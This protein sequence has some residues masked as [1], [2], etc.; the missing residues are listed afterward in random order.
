MDDPLLDDAR[1][2]VT[3]H[4]ASA[5]AALRAAV[6][7]AKAGDPLAPVT[8]T[9]P[10]SVAGLAL[11][12]AL[13]RHGAV[14]TRFLPFARLAE[15]LGAP[16]LAASGLRPLVT[17]VRRA[18]VRR[19][20]REHDGPLA[21]VAG[22]PGT[23]RS[24]AATFRD[25]DAAPP[26]ALAALASRGPRAEAVA[27]LYRR[28]R[29]LTAGFY[30]ERDLA[31]AAAAAVRD[32]D[33]VLDDVGQVVV[34]LPGRPGAGHDDLIAA[35]AEASLLRVVVGLTGDAAADTAAAE[36]VARLEPLLGTPDRN[37]PGAPPTAQRCV[38]VPDAAE[39]ARFAAREVAAHLDAGVPLHRL[40]V[41]TPRP[42][43]ALHRLHDVFT[44]AGIPHHLRS[45][46]RLG[47]SAA[48]RGLR[49]LLALAEG[50]LARQDLVA[51]IDAAPVLEHPAGHPAPVSDW[52]RLS[53]E[54][55]VVRGARQW[56]AR[57]NAHERRLAA[58]GDEGVERRGGSDSVGTDVEIASRARRFAGELHALLH[59]APAG[60]WRSLAQWATDLLVR[61]LGT[62]AQRDE[63][64]EA[65]RDAFTRV[66]E[67]LHGLA[68]LD[69]VD[70]EPS[71]AVFRQAV[72]DV[73]DAPAGRVG[74]FGHGVFLGTL[75][76]LAGTDF[77]H[78]HVVGMA[79][80]EVPA[81]RAEDALLSD[82][83]RRHAGVAPRAADRRDE[84][85]RFLAALASAPERVLV[86]ARADVR[87]QQA[88]LP[89]RWFLET[90]E[91]LLGEPVTTAALDARWEA[92]GPVTRLPS[93]QA[94]LE[95]APSP[96][97]ESERDVREMLAARRAGAPVDTTA[98]V[99]A[100]PH[101]AA[102]LAADAARH[103]GVPSPWNGFVGPGGAMVAD[104]AEPLSPTALET[105]ATCPARFFLGRVL[106]LGERD[107]P[108][109]VEQLGSADRGSLVHEI[110]ET[111]VVE[112]GS[113]VEPGAPWPPEA[114]ARA[115]AIADEVCAGYE[116]RGRTGHPLLWEYERRRILDQLERA[117][118]IDDVLRAEERSRPLA[119][120]MTFGIGEAAPVEV[121]L[122]D[123]R[124][125]RL[126]GRADRVDEAGARLVV[127]DYKTGSPSPYAALADD[128]VDAG[129]RLQLPVYALAARD[130]FGDRPVDAHYWFVSDRG[131][132][133]RVP[134]DGSLTPE[135]LDRFHAVLAT[136]VDGI[137]RGHFPA[138]PGADS[139]DYVRRRDSFEH[140]R[141]CA[142]DRLCTASRGDTWEALAD[143]PEM[144][145]FVALA[146]GGD[147]AG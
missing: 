110:L 13:A 51:W 61:Y 11:R 5:F 93:V 115:R 14:N 137:E 88:R 34:H 52:D 105:W 143:R 45:A 72:A 62:E 108:E 123:G 41:V 59:R 46:G 78:V 29:E 107:E 36:L 96:A 124:A 67:G 126:R 58:L 40:A 64:P 125:V 136:I 3:P 69:D 141:W 98:A 103:S 79:E 76:D 48:G 15:L 111:L 66:T 74:R 18:A 12:R 146:P 54:A 77:A 99:V 32:G 120:E 122:P 35:L 57:L 70:P 85:H 102:G 49:G 101:L 33:R 147:G 60:S 38:V 30:D 31:G 71:V 127:L 19:A 83:E 28:G 104:T 75:D 80:G 144:A 131:R 43:P 44:T 100:R 145:P 9:P 21:G 65:E 121:P 23:E 109:E 26:E 16:R 130:R 20:L 113:S 6:D 140:C 56:E 119:A 129:R 92:S 90:V 2:F 63:W 133:R 7:A 82:D 25:L 134:E 22:H 1:L 17:A 68:L 89:S 138:H 4:G 50:D 10:S 135:R 128:Y 139:W 91:G 73:L 95:R 132:Y 118:D 112:H 27:A 53:R 114:R 47:G 55:G 42:G 116:S 37:D 87:S 39:E 86:T 142:F 117:L 84:R 24:L 94:S 97:S 81:R 8:V 106:G